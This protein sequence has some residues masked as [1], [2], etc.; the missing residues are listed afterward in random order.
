VPGFYSIDQATAVMTLVAS[1]PASTD[2]GG[3]DYDPTTG[4]FYGLNDGTGLQGRGLYR[5]D[6]LVAGAPTYTLLTP[7][8]NNDTDIDGLAV[9][10]GRAYFVNDNSTAGQGIYVYNLI[11][12]S[13]ETS[14]PNPFTATNGIF[15][16][17]GWAPGLIPEPTSLALLG[18]GAL[19]GM[20]RR[21]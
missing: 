18:V 17:G 15:A 16:G 7:Y 9:G 5:I 19:F 13:F 4:A 12:A 10:A 21:G 1:T 20:R 2:F 3:F 6:N 11:T 8:P 14:L